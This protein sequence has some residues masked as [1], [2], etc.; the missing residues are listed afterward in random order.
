METDRKPR[1]ALDTS[2]KTIKKKEESEV[3]KC[4]QNILNPDSL[5]TGE[6]GN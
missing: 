2:E 4:L 5:V 3:D 6:E 1:L